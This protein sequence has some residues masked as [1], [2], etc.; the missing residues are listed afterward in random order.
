MAMTEV[1]NSLPEHINVM[2]LVTYDIQKKLDK[3]SSMLY[4]EN[5]RHT[6]NYRKV[7]ND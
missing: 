1:K 6:T 2:R 7:K 3:N 4:D 5:T